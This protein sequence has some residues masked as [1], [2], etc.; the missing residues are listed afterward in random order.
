MIT[1]YYFIHFR[2]ANSNSTKNTHPPSIHIQL[3]A[4]R[5]RV[6]PPSGP[7]KPKSS[8]AADSPKLSV[9]L[10]EYYSFSKSCT[11]SNPWS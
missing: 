10:C 3:F 1:P 4:F 9:S 11:S 7:R 8:F 5:S 6:A 2:S